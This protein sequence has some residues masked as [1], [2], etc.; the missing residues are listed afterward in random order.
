MRAREGG[1]EILCSTYEK[2]AVMR[3]QLATGIC[4]RS[5]GGVPEHPEKAFCV[6]AHAPSAPVLW[7]RAR[8]GKC[9]SVC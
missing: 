6:H 1:S 9:A 3:A 7:V 4:A 2:G 5:N 8:E